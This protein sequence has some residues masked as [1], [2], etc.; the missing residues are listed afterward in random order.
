VT[1][2]VP[3]VLV[4]DDHK[5]LAETLVIALRMH[6][7]DHVM[8]AED[9]SLE[10]V[11]KTVDEFAP[12]VVLLDLHLDEAGLSLPM[13]PPLVE[14]GAKVLILTA[15]RDRDDLLAECLEA[16]A[17]GLFDKSLTFDHLTAIIADAALGTT[18]LNPSA[19]NGVLASLKRV[20]VEDDER[21][22][23]FSLL[24]RREREVLMSLTEGKSAEE[25]S[26]Q[27]FVSIAT[28]RSQIRGIFQKLG[29]NSQIAAVA[30]A[31]RANWELA[32]K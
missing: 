17:T 18:I 29:V 6:G 16:G 25:I 5:V 1:G 7:F 20:R 30:L 28:V 3:R 31:R 12:D 14:H 13:I 23:P 9:L 26:S 19:R 10:G 22:K 11:R 2:S 27:Q 24:S 15:V 8:A 32:D 4:V 21:M